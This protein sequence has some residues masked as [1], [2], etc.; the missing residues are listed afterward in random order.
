[1]AYWQVYTHSPLCDVNA[2]APRVSPHHH[3][4]CLLVI[5]LILKTPNVFVC[6]QDYSYL[7]R[8]ALLSESKGIDDRRPSREEAR[9][10][11]YVRVGR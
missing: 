2:F 6:H 3:L 7:N 11:C 9:D 5:T 4:S 10:K 1:M 8:K